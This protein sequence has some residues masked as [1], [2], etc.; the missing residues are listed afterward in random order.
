MLDS[1][2]KFTQIVTSIS[3][4][5]GVLATVFEIN[6]SLNEARTTVQAI[7]LSSLE[8]VEKLIDKDNEIRNRIGVFQSEFTSEDLVTLIETHKSGEAVYIAPDLK[9]LRAIGRHYER[10][11]ALVKLGYIDFDL[12]YEI[13]PF[14]DGFWETT[15]EFRRMVRTSHWFNGKG[16]P[17][18]WSNFEYPHD[19]YMQAYYHRSGTGSWP[20]SMM[21]R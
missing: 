15:A 8:H 16:L 2:A 1:V 14:P 7:K 12:I 9:D 21:R 19:R 10:M 6:H 18:F 13:I 3:I 4:A 17:N 11:G 20:I 5:T